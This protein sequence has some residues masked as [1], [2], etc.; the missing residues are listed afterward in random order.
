MVKVFSRDELIETGYTDDQINNYTSHRQQLWNFNVRESKN[1]FLSEAG[2]MVNIHKSYSHI[3]NTMVVYIRDHRSKLLSKCHRD[4]PVEG[5]RKCTTSILNKK[6]GRSIDD[7][8]DS[9][10][11][12][13][14][15]SS[16]SSKRQ[17][18]ER[19]DIS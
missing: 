16:S 4:D 8:C 19:M 10:E 15:S 11:D 17:R 18:V 12:I 14:V 9:L 13:Y 7:I 5:L 2:I 1:R 6:R 3:Y